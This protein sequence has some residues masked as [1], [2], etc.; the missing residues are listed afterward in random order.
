MGTQNSI[1]DMF[2][3]E[4]EEL[5]EALTEGLALM[6][7]GAH[8]DETVNA[9]FRAVHSI[10]GGAGAFKLSALVGF[11][12]RFETVL[13]EIRGHRLDLDSEILLTL[14]RSADHL[15][16]LVE[17]ARNGDI[18]DTGQTVEFLV[19]LDACLGTSAQDDCADDDDTVGF[20]AI[21]LDLGD[22]GG[23]FRDDA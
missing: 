19:S 10:K 8:N 2:F 11:A 16:D 22:L 3:E 15:S 18:T 6:S 9:V 5:L 17:D 14:Q 1:R 7:T 23:N 12:H 21:T 20:A 13:D 4:S